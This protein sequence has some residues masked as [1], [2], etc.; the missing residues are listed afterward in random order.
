MKP[1]NLGDFRNRRESMN[2]CARRPVAAAL[3]IT[4]LAATAL[5][6]NQPNR[7]LTPLKV[8]VVISRYEGDKKVSSFPYILAVTAN[9]T[10]GVN[11][12]MGSQVP[13]P[14]A[15][16]SIEYKSVGT[17]IDCSATSTDDGRFQVQL[18]I[19]DSSVAERRNSD[20]PPTL[21]SFSASNMV[22]LKDGQTTQFSAAA[23]KT[24]GEV[25]RV[26]ITMTVEK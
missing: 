19:E 9:H 5:A 15:A 14:V 2:R 17:N 25:V 8:Q 12:K 13:V 6:Q 1:L 11:L 3:M 21:R 23:D 16:D 7:P 4:T 20:F 24:T 18:S 26:D 10:Q 22:V